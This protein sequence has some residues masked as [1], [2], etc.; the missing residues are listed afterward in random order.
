MSDI[1]IVVSTEFLCMLLLPLVTLASLRR[2][3]ATD[4]F[5][6]DMSSM[7]WAAWIGAFLM[8]AF[9]MDT[10]ASVA[11]QVGL[12]ILGS[13]LL[14]GA[15]IDRISAYAP[16][17]IIIPFCIMIFFVGV[18]DPGYADLFYSILLGLLLYIICI[19]MWIPQEASGYR[20][21]PPADVAALAAPFILFGVEI[22]TFA[23][24][25]ASSVVLIAILRIPSLAPI[26]SKAEAV[27]SGA[28]DVHLPD[29]PAV[30][31]LSVAFPIIFVAKI[32]T[33]LHISQ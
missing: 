8:G 9:A 1:L 2:I 18:D 14:L 25:L 15:W 12:V 31:F 19:A 27:K 17:A 24:Y 13:L 26:F 16:D 21:V 7:R 4:E 28:Q 33:L 30:T 10:G 23:V 20:V 3:K 6:Y 32:V 29:R 5:T 22:A 11:N